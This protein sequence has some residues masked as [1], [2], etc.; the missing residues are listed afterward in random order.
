MNIQTPKDITRAELLHAG[1]ANNVYATNYPGFLELEA[2]DRISAGNGVKTDVVEGKGSANNLIS[3]AIFQKLEGIG[4]PTHYVGPGSNEASKIVLKTTP[5]K[6]EILGRFFLTG[7]F[8]R[9]YEVEKMTPAKGVFVEY[10][11]KSDQ[12]GDPPI[13]RVTIEELEILTREEIEYVDEIT[14]KVAYAL[15][16]FFA[17]CNGKLIDFKIEVGKLPDGK[18]I[19][20]DEVSPDTCRIVDMETGESLDKDRFRNDMGGV[21]EAYCEMAKRVGDIK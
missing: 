7:S 5:I 17:Q 13:D 18:I 15:R 2:T 4:I 21:A 14:E 10:T 8:A 9:R 3:T 12:S 16:D 20:I 19:V 1:K 6:L 11:Y